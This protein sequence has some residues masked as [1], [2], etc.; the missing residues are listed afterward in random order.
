MLDFWDAAHSHFILGFFHRVHSQLSEVLHVPMD[1]ESWGQL[2][3]P[4]SEAI[5]YVFFDAFFVAYF[6]V[7][8][9]L[10]SG[11]GSCFSCIE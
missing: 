10:V 11:S 4:Q 3:K 6:Q 2:R 5:S 8:E 7:R 1:P 9:L